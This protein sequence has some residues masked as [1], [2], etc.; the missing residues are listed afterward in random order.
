M[1][2]ICDMLE[3]KRKYQK[4]A[5]LM[6]YCVAADSNNEALR[7]HWDRLV[8]KTNEERRGEMM[9]ARHYIP[10]IMCFSHFVL[11]DDDLICTM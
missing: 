2:D 6:Y 11:S 5:N 8:N 9:N 7:C 10:M 1:L 3:G 4:A